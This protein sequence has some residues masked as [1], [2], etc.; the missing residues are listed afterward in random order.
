[1]QNIL[2]SIIEE[3]HALADKQTPNILKYMVFDPSRSII[4]KP[5]ITDSNEEFVLRENI[6]LSLLVF[7]MED[8]INKIDQYLQQYHPHIL[9]IISSVR[10]SIRNEQYEIASS[11][12]DPSDI[13]STILTLKYLLRIEQ[14]KA[15]K[16]IR[17][18]CM[19]NI[20]SKIGK[21]MIG[22]T[23]HNQPK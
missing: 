19:H 1:M 16:L 17:H 22:R 9:H 20:I 23:T 2:D 6:R 15:I 4:A 3:A 11:Y 7:R 14:D 5:T 12:L 8:D 13:L 21:Y 18:K 10:D